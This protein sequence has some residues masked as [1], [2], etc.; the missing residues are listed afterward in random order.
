MQRSAVNQT[1]REAVG[2][3]I[4]YPEEPLVLR[5]Q[6]T[7]AL[8][9]AGQKVAVSTSP[10]R[11][12]LSPHAAFGYC[13]QLQALA[14]TNAPKVSRVIII[15]PA[16]ANSMEHSGTG[17]A[18]AAYLPESAVFQT[19]LGDITVDTAACDEIATSSTVFS[20]NDIPHLESYAIELQLP[21]M[22][23]ALPEATLLPILISGGWRSSLAVAHALDLV[24]GP[25]LDDS[26]VVASVNLGVSPFLED[27]S[28]DADRLVAA[29]T[30]NAWKAVARSSQRHS[31]PTLASVM[32]L[33]SMSSATFSLL[34]TS[35]SSA[36]SGKANEQIVVYGAGIWTAL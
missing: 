27:A 6:I 3:G 36:L 35:D 4:F 23:Q 22:K 11:A 33:G 17:E 34:G 19:P 5:D 9:R 29:L 20:I 16:A 10:V 2:S 24:L 13:G 28:A 12:L 8:A 21:F 15:A 18:L 25:D 31:A 14:W 32:A 7:D 1:V 30:A 26:L